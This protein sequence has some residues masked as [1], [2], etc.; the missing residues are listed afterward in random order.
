MFRHCLVVLAVGLVVV[1]APRSLTVSAQGAAST[2]LRHVNATRVD[3]LRTWE[4]Y[5]VDGERSG[6]LRLRTSR[7][8][9]DMPARRVERL[10]QYHNGVRIWGA[11]VVRNSERGV[12]ASIFG[13][14]AP[15]L[16]LS[17]DPGLTA[18]QA[19]TAML[20]VAGPDSSVLRES[21]LL[22]LPLAS[23]EYRLA[24]E[25]VVGIAS[26]NDV[27]HLFVDATSGQELLRY[28]AIQRQSAV[29]SGRGVLGDQKKV[30]VSRWA[31]TYVAWDQLRPPQIVTYD[32]KGNL[33]RF[34]AFAEQGSGG[35][36]DADIASKGD[37]TWTDPAVVDAHAHVGM[38]LD[39]FYKRFGRNGID[40][41]NKPVFIFTNAVSQQGAASL[42]ASDLDDYSMN[43]AAFSIGTKGHLFF[44]NGIP[45]GYYKPETGQ[46]WTYTAGA[47]D[48]AAHELTHLVLHNSSNLI[49]F[50]ESGALNEA[51]ADMMG[52]SAEFFFRPPGSGV[53]QA[54]YTIGKDVIRGL[55]AGAQNGM[56]SMAN[57]GLFGDPDHYFNRN[58][59][60]NNQYEPIDN[61]YV[62]SNSGVA[63]HA[64]YLAVEG[65]THRVSRQTV[66]GVGAANR[67]QI[68][69]VFFRAFTL[70][71][72]S[73]A[74]F[75]TAR[76]ATTQAAIDL[77]GAGSAV[78]RAV[79]QAWSAVGV[80]TSSAILVTERV[81]S[82]RSG[83]ATAVR[84][85]RTGAFS[86]NLMANGEDFDVYFTYAT[87]ACLTW[88]GLSSGGGLLLPPS[89]FIG[90]A[91]S[92][93]D[94]EVLRMPIRAGDSIGVW[95]VNAGS[96]SG[97]FR[98][99]MFSESAP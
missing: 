87:E 5:L 11:D 22:V 14:L 27:V 39:Y 68:E 8:D 83:W 69:K 99:E 45:Q 48:I 65:G 90:A 71:M 59:R 88:R 18:D 89:C 63:N 49:Y 43:A 97:Q 31:G 1:T 56:R 78:T 58:W 62:H 92:G 51:F 32:L 80:P 79:D 74:S 34:K 46:N 60:L 82:A 67:E 91:L 47:L 16:S 95:V 33:Q 76:A 38:A 86:A 70:L 40:N 7:E 61:G 55:R 17:T 35:F 20:R 26:E 28:T 37:N 53:G 2:P 72:P 93:E 25:A 94:W 10:D 36:N 57:P 41:R 64:F 30:S 42:S 3:D 75:V 54:D 81:L 23:G 77:Y 15:D 96:T 6:L 19:V 9:P 13:V 84:S 98:L 12:P 24:Y 29:G 44:G 50:N 21:E 85:V 66:Q 52:K 73:Y 4:R